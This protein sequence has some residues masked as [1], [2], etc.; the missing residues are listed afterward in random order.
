MTVNETLKPVAT[1]RSIELVGKIQIIATV[2][3][4]DVKLSS[5]GRGGSARLYTSWLRRS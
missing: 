5:V 1:E 2:G 4:K 3:N